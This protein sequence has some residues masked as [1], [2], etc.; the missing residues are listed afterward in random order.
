[1]RLRLCLFKAAV[2]LLASLAGQLLV[3]LLGVLCD[4]VKKLCGSLFLIEHW[5]N[6]S[7]LYAD[8]VAHIARN[9]VAP[10]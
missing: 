8:S 2:N 7:N 1:M 9:G 5:S 6:T 4:G 10:P 3:A